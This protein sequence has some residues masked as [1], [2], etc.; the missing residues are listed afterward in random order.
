MYHFGASFSQMG[1]SPVMQFEGTLVVFQ[2]FSEHVPFHSYCSHYF[3]FP[4]YSN[5]ASHKTALACM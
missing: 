4:G 5:H 2:L 1:A 3:V